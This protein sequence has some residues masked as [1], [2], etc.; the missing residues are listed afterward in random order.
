MCIN[1]SKV[2]ML[3]KLFHISETFPRLWSFSS[4]K[5]R[6]HACGTF[7]LTKNFFHACKTFPRS[8]NFSTHVKIFSIIELFY[9]QF[10]SCKIVQNLNGNVVKYLNGKVFL[11]KIQKSFHFLSFFQF[12]LTKRKIELDYFQLKNK[13]FS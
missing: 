7:P 9:S 13:C 4:I 3:V 6:F 10:V 2:F 1:I 11:F 12:F 5:K 8:R